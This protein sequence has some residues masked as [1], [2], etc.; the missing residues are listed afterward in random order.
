MSKKPEKKCICANCG[1]TFMAHRR[2]LCN[3]CTRV[4]RSKQMAKLRESRRIDLISSNNSLEETGWKVC[5]KC[6]HKRMISEFGT[7]QNNRMGKLNK[8]CDKC[9]TRMYLS[10]SRKSEGFDEVY[11]RRRAYTANSVARQR[12]AK[13]FDVKVSNVSLSDLDWVCKPQHLA[14][15]YNDQNGKCKYCG[16]KL[17][18]ADTQID[19]VIPLSRGGKH[20]LSNI[21]LVCK[22]CNYLKG[23][24]TDLEFN[25]FVKQYAQRFLMKIAEVQD[26]EP[27]R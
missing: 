18:A 3:E 2:S 25:E 21:A 8:I 14:K 6:H 19:H 7:S 5:T 13:E 20:D 15:L 17:N 26:K 24:R 4:H 16:V 11:W 9:L 12:Y 10:K 22:D 27:E 23:P 1:A